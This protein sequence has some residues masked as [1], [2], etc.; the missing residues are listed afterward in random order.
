MQSARLVGPSLEHRDSFIRTAR[1]FL[2]E[3][4]S[5]CIGEL[6]I[7]RWHGGRL[8]ADFGSYVKYLR[9]MA[10]KDICGSGRMPETRLWL[11]DHGEVVGILTV[12]H[13]LNDFLLQGGGHIAYAIRPSR[14]GQ[15]YGN[16]ILRL[17]L[18]EARKLGLDRVLLVCDWD[19]H[20]SRKVIEA[21]G[22]LLENEVEVSLDGETV[23]V[24]RYWI[25]VP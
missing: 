22:G 25:P 10:D 20:L 16:L 19:N 18:V 15:G 9:D 3:D 8:D 17:A 24:F 6:K 2:E 7:E 11:V 21:N 1:E 13:E 4:C 23:R 14:R 5:V 12:R